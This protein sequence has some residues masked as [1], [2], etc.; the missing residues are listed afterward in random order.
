MS[1][2][3]AV[4][5]IVGTLVLTGCADRSH[6]QPLT[7]EIE[8]QRTLLLALCA[9][10]LAAWPVVLVAGLRRRRDVTGIVKG[11]ATLVVATLV[12]F[13]AVGQ[14]TDWLA[15]QVIGWGII[16]TVALVVL[17][18][19]SGIE[20]VLGIPLP[21]VVLF[22]VLYPRADVLLLYAI[23]ALVVQSIVV[24]VYFVVM[25]RD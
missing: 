7:P 16:G 10:L 22:G 11:L 3:R 21:L 2:G 9:V 13:T 17:G 4:A 14:L 8:A 5:L 24:A 23:P 1:A 6:A 12:I 19:L 15:T 18:A 25:I 20:A